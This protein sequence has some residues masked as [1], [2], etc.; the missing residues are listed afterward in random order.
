VPFAAA[1]AGKCYAQGL[2]GAFHQAFARLDDGGASVGQVITDEN[3]ERARAR[4]WALTAVRIFPENAKERLLRHPA[5]IAADAGGALGAVVLADALARLAW[6]RH[7]HGRIA[8]SVSDDQGERRVLCL[9]AGER[10][11]RR[12]QFK[13]LRQ[14]LKWE[15]K[16]AEEF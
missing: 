8:L 4:E 16:P 11:V 7:P 14:L 10:Q 13:A 9:E 1:G 15:K 5:V 12:S 6:R 2:T 3:G